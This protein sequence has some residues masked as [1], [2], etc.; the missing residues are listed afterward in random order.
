MFVGQWAYDRLAWYETGT[1]WFAAFG[2][3]AV[4]FVVTIAAGL[5]RAL[6]T[7][8][9]RSR[10]RYS[11]FVS[12]L[13]PKRNQLSLVPAGLMSAIDLAILV[14]TAWALAG[15]PQWQAVAIL[16]AASRALAVA[17]GLS[18][19]RL[20]VPGSGGIRVCAAEGTQDRTRTCVCLRYSNP[21]S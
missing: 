8:R 18:S 5:R 13:A 11:M 10:R 2:A 21:S 12:A 3:C 19:G 9:Q 1:T 20:G 7:L 14:T 4:A 17:T 6:A 16:P 15:I